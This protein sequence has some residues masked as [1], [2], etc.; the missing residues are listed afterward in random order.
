MDHAGGRQAQGASVQVIRSK[1]T[2]A[3][4]AAGEARPPL[5][6][7]A[8]AANKRGLL[9]WGKGCVTWSERPPHCSSTAQAGVQVA[10]ESSRFTSLARGRWR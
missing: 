4:G 6:A 3:H 1:V 2:Q 8:C 9:C 5:G 7:A 10:R